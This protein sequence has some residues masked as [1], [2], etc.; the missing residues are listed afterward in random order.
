LRKGQL[1]PGIPDRDC[2]HHRARWTQSRNRRKQSYKCRDALDEQLETVSA[3]QLRGLSRS[4]EISLPHEIRI[5][6][7]SRLDCV[8][9]YFYYGQVL[10]STGTAK[11]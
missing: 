10:E 2:V 3:Q 8:V 1:E 4:I 6:K 9:W 7:N 11:H 5:S